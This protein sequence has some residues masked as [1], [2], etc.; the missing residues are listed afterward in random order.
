[1]VR[2]QVNRMHDVFQ[3]E[4]FINSISVMSRIKKLFYVEN[5]KICFHNDVEMKKRKHTI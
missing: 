2:T 4:V 1:M 3:T 5:Q